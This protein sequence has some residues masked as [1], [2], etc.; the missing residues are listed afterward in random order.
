MFPMS[1]TNNNPNEN[2]G[3]RKKLTICVRL[4]INDYNP[5][6]AVKIS[7]NFILETKIV[8]AKPVTNTAQKSTEPLEKDYPY[9][10]LYWV[11]V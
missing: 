5:L 3:V 4:V 11:M 7:S 2:P 9:I 6:T 10:V 1:L 8:F